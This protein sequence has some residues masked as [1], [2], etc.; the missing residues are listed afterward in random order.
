MPNEVA[1]VP[2]SSTRI[3]LGRGPKRF[4]LKSR[5]GDPEAV[6]KNRCKLVLCHLL[7]LGPVI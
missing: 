5:G 2:S 1:S 4:A 3:A 7:S 6:K